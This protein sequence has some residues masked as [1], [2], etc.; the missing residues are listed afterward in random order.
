MKHNA[1]H[2]GCSCVEK[3]HQYKERWSMYKTPSVLVCTSQ[4]VVQS[5]GLVLIA[6]VCPNTG[7]FMGVY[8]GLSCL[9]ERI[10][11]HRDRVSGCALPY[12]HRCQ[13]LL[14]VLQGQIRNVFTEKAQCYP[15]CMPVTFVPFV[16][17]HFDF[18]CMVLLVS[19]ALQRGIHPALF[20]LFWTIADIF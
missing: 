10:R 13:G 20:G 12:R 7:A 11:G 8:S 4:F 18:R 9:F 3:Y 16:Q 14:P 19:M 17:L 5:N 6:L 2:Q 15:P 1:S